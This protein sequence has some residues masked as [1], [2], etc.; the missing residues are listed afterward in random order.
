MLVC[1]TFNLSAINSFI[2]NCLNDVVAAVATA[3]VIIIV[4][5]ANE[6]YLGLQA[7]WALVYNQVLLLM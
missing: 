1:G 6:Q 2:S 3:K 5:A 4:K 7:G